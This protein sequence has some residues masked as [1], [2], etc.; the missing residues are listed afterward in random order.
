[1]VF[2]KIVSAHQ[3][4]TSIASLLNDNKDCRVFQL[5]E[6]FKSLKKGS[7]SIHDCYQTIKHTIGQLADVD[8]LIFNKQLILQTL[9]GIPKSY[10]IVVNLISFQTPIPY[11]FQTRSLL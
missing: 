6:H 9:H 7:L 5:E 8:H 1:M 11:F 2:S 3:L 10:N 4:W